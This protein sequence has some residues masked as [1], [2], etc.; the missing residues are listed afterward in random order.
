MKKLILTLAA[1]C[2]ALTLTGCN[3]TTP[4][5]DYLNTNKGSSAYHPIMKTENGYYYNDPMEGLGLK[6]HDNATG[7]DIY[8]CAKPE[9]SH[10]GNSFCTADALRF[11]G[12]RNR[13]KDRRSGIEEI[14]PCAG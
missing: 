9:C 7:K 13:R 3:N 5:E 14:F 8:L 1:A 2:I 12:S 10:D 4:T 6:Y 11:H